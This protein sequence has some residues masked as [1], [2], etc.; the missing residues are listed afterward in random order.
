MN[1]LRS[2][3]LL[4]GLLVL[5]QAQTYSPRYF[6]RRTATL[7]GAGDVITIVNPRTAAA[8]GKV[9]IRGIYVSSS[10]AATVTAERDGA[11]P[12]GTALTIEKHSKALPTSLSTAYYASTVGVGT[13]INSYPVSASPSFLSVPFEGVALP[14]DGTNSNFTIRVASMTGTITVFI[15][16]EEF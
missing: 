2:V 4:L 5:G 13:V 16:W 7:S 10:V 12:A 8:R 6:V 9:E 15:E 1:L 3:A 11:T 14:S